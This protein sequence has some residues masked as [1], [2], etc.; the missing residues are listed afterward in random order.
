MPSVTLH[1]LLA[2]RAMAALEQRRVAPPFD[3][4]LPQIRN[5]FR[6]GALGPDLG[7]FPGGHRFLSDLAHCVASA[8]LTRALAQGAKTA[9]ERAFAWGWAT[10]VVADQRIHPWIGLAV[11]RHR[12]LAGDA[13]LSGDEDPVGHVR[14]ETGLDAWI[15][16]RHP[17]VSRT[18][19]RAVF[20]VSS[21]GF[22]SQSFRR[23][24]GVVLDPRLF[25]ASHSATTRV[26]RWALFATQVMG[27]ELAGR[28]THTA[29]RLARSALVGLSR[30]APQADDS[31]SLAY[32]TPV[33]PEPWLLDETGKEIEAFSRRF[34]ELAGDGF[35][36]L[37]N[38][39][40]D[41]GE[42]DS[43]GSRHATAGRTVRALRAVS[44]ST[45]MPAA[46][47]M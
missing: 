34:L 19:L 31:I 36:R 6:Q 25:L 16:T 39:N 43:F 12:R 45:A 26:A 42:L 14:V 27:R 37:E 20:D 18:V 40:L 30:R 8:D 29:L 15:S 9:L 17:E 35:E 3:I 4:R 24:Y 41:T 13:F 11:G 32:L 5:A 2:E 44:A 21:V 38:R 28:G 47:G 1:L 7:Y 23:S 10:H 46:A 33:R 22:L